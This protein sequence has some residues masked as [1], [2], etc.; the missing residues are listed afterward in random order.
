MSYRL[1][2][3]AVLVVDDNRHM[4]GLISE[5]LRGLGI[6]D[7][8]MLTDAATAFREIKITAVDV[9]ITDHAMSPIS[10]IEFVTM[11]R[12]SDDSPDRFVPVI[13]V[14]GYSD[15]GTVRQARR[16]GHRI[17]GQAD[18][19]QGAIHAPARSDRERPAVHPEQD[20]FWSRPAPQVRG[21]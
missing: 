16:R 3:L 8:V 7:L 2:R 21:P 4:L 20:L 14:T 6:R 13:M 19:G 15:L 17:P 5:I 1:D 18:L 12:T 10:G 11:L 9:V